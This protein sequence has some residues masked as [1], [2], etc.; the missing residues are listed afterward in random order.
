MLKRF[1]TGLPLL[2]AMCLATGPLA[3]AKLYKWTDANGEV[4]YS[5]QPPPANVKGPV[6]ETQRKPSAAPPPAAEGDAKPT[7]GPK[8]P[9]EQEAEFQQRRVEAAEKDAADRKAQEE[10]QTR[11]KNCEQAKQHVAQ[12]QSGVRITR[13]DANTGSNDYLDDAQIAAELGRARQI[14]DSWCKP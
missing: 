9:Q 6:K 2:L 1:W 7:G 4:H 8:T 5:D 13:Y 10:Q 11:R 3:A 12:L 14:A